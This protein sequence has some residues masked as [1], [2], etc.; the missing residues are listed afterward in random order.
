MQ[1]MDLGDRLILAADVA[2]FPMRGG[3][4]VM[5]DMFAQILK[6]ASMISDSGTNVHL[7]ISSFHLRTSSY[8]LL[9]RIRYLKL[10]VRL[11]VDLHLASDSLDFA[12]E[13]MLLEQYSPEIVT[14]LCASG[15]T[16][17][18]E[19]RSFLKRSEVVAITVPAGFGDPDSYAQFG[20]GLDRAVDRMRPIAKAS[21]VSG[22][23]VPRV[24]HLGR[25]R[26]DVGSSMTLMAHQWVRPDWFHVPIEDLNRMRMPKIAEAINAGADRVIVPSSFVLDPNKQGLSSEQIY[27]TLREIEQS[28]HAT[29]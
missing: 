14:V 6:M 19:A 21:A 18:K 23:L 24:H 16:Q 22:I 12:S 27:M 9:E 26:E 20:G 28:I 17:L 3:G 25:S 2:P 1:E 13:C 5:N 11:M 10:N 15:V 7:K 4:T 8:K 29:A